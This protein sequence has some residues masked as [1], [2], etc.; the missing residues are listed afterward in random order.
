MSKSEKL[1]GGDHF[2]NGCN[3]N[4]EDHLPSEFYQN[5]PHFKPEVLGVCNQLVMYDEASFESWEYIGYVT[6]F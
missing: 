5:M 2:Y 4:N 1:E 3:P 6:L